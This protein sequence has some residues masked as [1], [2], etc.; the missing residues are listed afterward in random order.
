MNKLNFITQLLNEGVYYFIFLL[1]NSCLE[2]CIF[3]VSLVVFFLLSVEN[4]F[5]CLKSCYN[6]ASCSLYSISCRLNYIF[7]DALLS[8]TNYLVTPNSPTLVCQ[9]L[10]LQ[11]IVLSLDD[12]GGSKPMPL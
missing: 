8:P 11:Y 9:V 1:F 6:K 7:G 10:V 3:H 4:Q 5:L 2:K 12:I